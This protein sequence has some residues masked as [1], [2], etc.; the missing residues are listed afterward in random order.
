[1]QETLK[2][3]VILCELVNR[4]QPRAVKKINS[5]EMPFAQRENIQSFCDAVYTHVTHLV[6]VCMCVCVLARVCV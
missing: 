2:S 1:M 5:S 6:C 4:V 3:G